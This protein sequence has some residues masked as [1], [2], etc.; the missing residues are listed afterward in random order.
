MIRDQY[1]CSHDCCVG[2][3]ITGDGYH[4]KFVTFYEN[5]EYFCFLQVDDTIKEMLVEF[6]QII[7]GKIFHLYKNFGAKIMYAGKIQPQETIIKD[8]FQTKKDNYVIFNT[9]TQIK[10]R[11]TKRIKQN[12][13]FQ[14]KSIIHIQLS[15]K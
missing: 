15:F 8:F 12:Q 11:S 13:N 7:V 4:Y 5:E 3:K 9:R 14:G 10:T 6:L 1:Y 2:K